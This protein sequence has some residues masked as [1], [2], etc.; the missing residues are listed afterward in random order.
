MHPLAEGDVV[1]ARVQLCSGVECTDV[2]LSRGH[3][4]CPPLSAPPT[5]FGL[6]LA[7]ERICIIISVSCIP[8]AR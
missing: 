6:G 1:R 7:N 5:G 2:R 8:I 4:L 3:R